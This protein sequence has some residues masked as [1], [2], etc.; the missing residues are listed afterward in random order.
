M[1][2]VALIS[3][4]LDSI[5]AIRLMQEQGIEVEALNFRTVFTCCQDQSAQASHE[6]GVR[7][8]VVGQEDDYLDLLKNPKFGYG[9]GANPC[10]DCRIYMFQ[11]AKQFME[12]VGAKFIISGEVV[13]QR[14]MSQKRND[15]STISHHSDLDD[16][17]L[18]PLS[19][20]LL[21]PTLPEREGWVD[22]E[23]LGDFQGRSRKGLIELANRLGVKEIP[24]PSTGCSLTEPLFSKKV[25]DLNIHQPDSKRWDYDTLSVGR[26][27]RLNDK[28]KVI[29]GKDAQ[30]NEKIRYMK[31]MPEAPSTLFFEP[32][33]FMGPN[34]LLLGSQD[35]EHVPVVL[36]LM[37]R[38]SRGLEEENPVVEMSYSGG[39]PKERQERSTGENAQTIS[40]TLEESSAA[41]ELQTITEAPSVRA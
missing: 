41:N 37:A 36:G 21:P 1:K 3:G 29:V 23:K 7:L 40:Y 39:T 2:C 31:E 5:L 35:T 8:T 15:L 22:R 24:T 26:H 18:R 27:F 28:V 14:P 11:K 4:G 33:G 10:V 12:Q 20:K 38:Y 34:A 16:L 6:L 13:G 30:D 9:K 25:Y 19:A 32:I 17:L